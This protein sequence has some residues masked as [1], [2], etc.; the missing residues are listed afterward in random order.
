MRK[1]LLICLF[2]TCF[3]NSHS[4]VPVANTSMANGLKNTIVKEKQ[5]T[6]KDQ[7][8]GRITGQ[9][10]IVYVIDTVQ[11]QLLTVSVNTI[12]QGQ[13]F[14][15]RYFFEQNKLQKAVSGIVN[16]GATIIQNIYDYD[17]EDRTMKQK[18]LETFSETDE[19][20]ALL[21]ESKSFLAV[22]QN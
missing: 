5:G 8:S 11:H 13:K 15:Y 21:K 3:S 9:Y 16:N 12:M 20:Y 17:E 19:K 6:Y 18:D 10:T 22:L 2:V 1:L 4:Q 14:A 7:N